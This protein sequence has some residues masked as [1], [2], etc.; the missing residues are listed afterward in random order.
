M[1][2]WPSRN[3][4]KYTNQCRL[5]TPNFFALNTTHWLP[6]GVD[7]G[8]RRHG[9]AVE[10]PVHRVLCQEPDERGPSV[11]RTRSPHPSLPGWNQCPPPLLS[12]HE[13]TNGNHEKKHVI[14]TKSTNIQSIVC[15]LLSGP[16]RRAKGRRLQGQKANVPSSSPDLQALVSDFNLWWTSPT[17]V[18]VSISIK[19]GPG[20]RSPVHRC[21]A[22][23]Q[24]RLTNL[25]SVPV[26]GFASKPLAVLHI[27]ESHL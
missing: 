17:L 14:I 19:A 4:K 16:W 18:K 21:Q 26:L 2:F 25:R 8:L 1:G 3:V 22:K 24:L 9:E 15:R 7:S 10:D 5:T 13:K 6:S 12:H 20:T 11:P 23:D 27:Y